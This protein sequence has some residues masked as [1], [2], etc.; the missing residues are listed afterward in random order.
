MNNNRLIKYLLLLLCVV[1]AGVSFGQ[2]PITNY[3]TDVNGRVR[4][5]VNSTVNNY[6]ILQVRHNPSD[7]FALSTSMTMGQANT[8]I[9]TESLEAYPQDHYQ[10]LEFPISSPNDTDGDGIDDI[11]EFNS[12]PEDN[13]LNFA[14]SIAAVNGLV[15]IDNVPSFNTLSIQLEDVQWNPFLDGKEFVKYIILDFWSLNPKV[16][17]INTNTHALHADFA[18]FLGVDHLAPSVEKGQVVYHPNVMSANGTLGTYAFNYSNGESLDFLTVQ[19]TQELLAASMPLL[20]NNLSYYINVGNEGEY[21]GGIPAVWGSGDNGQN[22][23]NGNNN[24]IVY[25]FC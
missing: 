14:A 5:E 20:Q 23:N 18:V 21:N 3:S 1:Q 9:I 7:T 4:L 22:N 12:I 19:R 24:N 8:T 15:T 10:V 6:Y 2:V 25:L 11:T 16:Y 17:F 13:P